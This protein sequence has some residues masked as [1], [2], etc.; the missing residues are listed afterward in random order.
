MIITKWSKTD[1]DKYHMIMLICRILKKDDT[2][3]LIYKT[4]TDLE[5]KF[6]VT[7][8]ETWVWDWHIHTIFK[9]DN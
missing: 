8:G 9:T 4:E 7:E 5:N 3:E 6:M 2:N 1:K